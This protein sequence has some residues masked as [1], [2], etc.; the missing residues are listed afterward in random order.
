MPT[1][2]AAPDFV[3]RIAGKPASPGVWARIGFFGDHSLAAFPGFMH[4]RHDSPRHE[5]T[6][7]VTR[8]PVFRPAPTIKKPRL[9]VAFLIWWVGRDSNSRPTD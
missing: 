7:F 2:G 3:E 9:R 8:H 4:G 5:V 6:F 1:L